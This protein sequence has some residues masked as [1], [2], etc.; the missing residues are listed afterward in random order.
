MDL[1]QRLYRVYFAMERRIVPELRHAQA[2]YH[3]ALRELAGSQPRW[4]DLGCGWHL[5]REW[6]EEE[7][8]ALVSTVPL[9]VGLEPDKEALRKH[10]TIEDR[11]VGTAS[12][13]PFRDHSFDLVSANMVVEHLEEPAIQFVEIRR[14]LKPGGIFIFH[15]PNLQGYVARTARRIPEALKGALIRL[16]EKR[17][18]ED[19]YPTFYRANTKRGIEELAE[20]TGFEVVRTARVT[21]TAQTAVVTPLAFL[22][23]IWLRML[24]RGTRLEPYRTNLIVQLRRA[25]INGAR[26]TSGRVRP[27]G[28]EPTTKAE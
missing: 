9:L 4:L 2:R 18:D 1:Y 8:R 22:E 26:D 11:V 23:L 13:L 6:Q 21:T 5:L 25:A 27:P 14:V 28:A 15:T 24:E 12:M 19:V 7:E 17:G 20:L 10:R 3:E 16:L